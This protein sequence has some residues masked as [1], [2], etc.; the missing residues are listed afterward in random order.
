M[1]KLLV[2]SEYWNYKVTTEINFND[3]DEVCSLLDLDTISKM[4]LSVEMGD[5]WRSWCNPAG[6]DDPNKVYFDIEIF[7]ASLKGWL[8]QGISLDHSERENIPEGIER[9]CLELAARFCADA[10]QNCYFKEDLQRFP[11][12]GRHN[13]HR[14]LAQ[15]KLAQSVKKQRDDIFRI[16]KQS[17]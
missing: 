16:W 11:Q 14:A 12:I 6:E 15:F 1:L 2:E 4:G 7:E 8:S 5:A 9:I 13:L 10:L 3:Q 17:L